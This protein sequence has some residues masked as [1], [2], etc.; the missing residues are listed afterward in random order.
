MLLVKKIRMKNGKKLVLAIIN[1]KY[2]I[3]IVNAF[4]HSLPDI[5]FE[6]LILMNSI[7]TI[8]SKINKLSEF[9]SFEKMIK[10]C[11]LPSRI[12]YMEKTKNICNKDQQDYDFIQDFNKKIRKIPLFWMI[13]KM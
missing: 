6:L 4:I 9:T 8:L 5:K 10:T 1:Y 11:L 3:I 7:F 2:D 12:F 13:K